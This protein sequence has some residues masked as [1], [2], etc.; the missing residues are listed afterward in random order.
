[1]SPTPCHCLPV[2]VLLGLALGAAAQEGVVPAVPPLAVS[3]SRTAGVNEVDGVLWGAGD[4]YQIR[5]E[6]WGVEFHPAL[7][8]IAQ[9]N[10]A[11]TLRLQSLGR[12]EAMAP[13]SAT[14]RIAANHACRVEYERG[15]VT[16]CYDVGVDG[17]EQSFVFH[18]RPTGTGDLVVRFEMT[19]EL[20]ISL[21]RAG[22]RFERPGAGGFRL[23]SV[24]GIDAHGARVEGSVRASDNALELVLPAAFVDAA[25]LPLTLD[26]LLGGAFTVTGLTTDTNPNVAYD[27]SNDVYLVV[28]SA[29]PGVHA[30]RVS[31]TGIP[32]GTRLILSA[33]AGGSPEVANID[34]K[35]VFVVVYVNGG[36]VIE[37]RAVKAG[38]GAIVAGSL[39]MTLGIASFAMIGGS[40]GGDPFSPGL[41]LLA[42]RGPSGNVEAA[43]VTVDPS[44]RPVFTVG[45]TQTVSQ[46]A[47]KPSLS[48]TN[49]AGGRYAIVYLRN[50]AGQTQVHARM[51]DNSGQAVTP[52]QVV[53]VTPLI[54]DRPAIGGDGTNWVAAW[55]ENTNRIHVRGLRYSASQN[56][57][58]PA[59][60]V[61][62]LSFTSFGDKPSVT[63]TGESCVVGYANLGAFAHSVD[64]LGCTDCEGQLRPSLGVSVPAGSGKIESSGPADDALLVG[65]GVG[66]VAQRFHA[67]DGLVTSRGGGCGAGGVAHATCARSPNPA[68]AHR[69]V[70]ALPN[71]PTIFV[72]AASESP[73]PCGTCNLVPDV[74]SAIMLPMATSAAGEASLPVPIP[75]S[76]PLRGVPLIE[77]WVTVDLTTPACATFRFD[78]SDALRVVIE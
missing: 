16:E 68:F 36:T 20:E 9:A 45:P 24:V 32:L 58:T 28:W 60:P 2:V 3:L 30:H 34:A 77:Q 27:V 75:A 63:W 21:D 56:T 7:P 40:R 78:L 50:I 43:R 70:G 49:A 17:V 11:L 26:P 59:T 64:L 67:D 74:L 23:G 5:F 76:S 46:Q 35:D 19:T 4:G 73:F 72:V 61:S 44:G 62:F 41:A 55:V 38:D 37:G 6:P 51:L 31:A 53:S 12:G 52:E 10:D 18:E 66:I 69:L 14:P 42:W 1:M 8:A 65:V 25:A 15:L 71:A 22:L 39:S 57:I 48:R 13:M 33:T 47:D 54:Q 29:G